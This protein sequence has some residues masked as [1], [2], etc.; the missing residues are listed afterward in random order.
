MTPGQHR[1]PRANTG[2]RQAQL[3]GLHVLTTEGKKL[4]PF[5]KSSAKYLKTLLNMTLSRISSFRW[6][7]SLVSVVAE[8]AV[9]K[10]CLRHFFFVVGG[11]YL[12]Y[13]ILK[14]CSPMRLFKRRKLNEERM[15]F[16]SFFPLLLL[17]HPRQALLFPLAQK[18]YLC[19]F[20]PF[21]PFLWLPASHPS[22][23]Q[24]RPCRWPRSQKRY[25]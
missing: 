16:L 17:P 10:L 12:P 25:I 15:L 4:P 1:H 21:F 8:V 3:A 23:G 18:R 14:T 19:S 13:L 20:S 5:P 6:K 24:A 11:V 9:L 2:T 7:T 22:P